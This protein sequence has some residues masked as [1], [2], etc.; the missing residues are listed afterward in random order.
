MARNGGNRD[1]SSQGMT[2]S[3]H[4]R[5]NQEA[6]QQIN[7]LRR[8]ERELKI[9]IAEQQELNRLILENRD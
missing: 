4:R 9:T 3:N 2:P 7:D 6:Q 8:K 5:A 1:R